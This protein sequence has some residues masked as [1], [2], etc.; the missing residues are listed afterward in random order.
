M[1]GRDRREAFDGPAHAVL[2][3]QARRY[4]R[5][6]GRRGPGFHDVLQHL[7][8]AGLRA[9]DRHDPA[10]AMPWPVFLSVALRRAGLD[11]LRRSSARRRGERLLPR[12]KRI[13]P[14]LDGT[15]DGVPAEDA[16]LRNADL[17]LDLAAFAASLP[18][19]LRRVLEALAGSTAAEA[20]RLLHLPASTVRHRR[21][22]IR[23]RAVEAGFA[24]YL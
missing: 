4:A 2:L 21:R 20:A 5:L 10:K 9:W 6:L 23:Q 7:R 3:R 24:A 18:A 15:P 19:V 11:L 22:Q 8:L 13:A 14:S 12:R 1:A 17:A 16:T